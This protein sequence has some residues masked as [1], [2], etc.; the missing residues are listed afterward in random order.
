MK[1]TKQNLPQL[2]LAAAMALPLAAYAAEDAPPMPGFGPGAPGIQ[3]PMMDGPGM[4]AP[5]GFDGPRS[6]RFDGPGR[7]G[8]GSFGHGGF[9]RGI[10][11]TEAQEDKIFTILHGQAPY[12]REQHKAEEK[13]MRGLHE[14]RDAARFDDAAAIKLAQTAAQAHANITLA[15]IRTHQKVLAVLTPEQRKALDERKPRS[16][17]LK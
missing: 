1:K 13:A 7:E 3:A 5:P 2:L 8:P 16:G 11:L 12:L 15:E 10:E 17:G 6:G 9:L 14:L 4:P